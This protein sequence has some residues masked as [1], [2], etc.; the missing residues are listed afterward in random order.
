MFEVNG[1]VSLILRFRLLYHSVAKSGTSPPTPLLAASLGEGRRKEYRTSP[2][3]GLGPCAAFVWQGEK[4]GI[5]N[6]SR[7][8]TQPEERKINGHYLPASEGCSAG[9]A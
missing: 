2:L 3:W 1:L 6:L 9:G 5:Q 8:F 4:E 7:L